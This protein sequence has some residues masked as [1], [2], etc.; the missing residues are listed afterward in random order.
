[1]VGATGNQGS[2]VAKTFL[3]LSNWHVRCLTRNPSSAASKSLAA[4]GAEIVQGD[5]EDQV[6]LQEAFEGA[7]AIF[8]NTDFRATYYAT[9]AKLEAEKKSVEPASQVAFDYETTSGKNAANVAAALPNL[10]R[11]IYSALGPMKGNSG[12]KNR[13]LHPEAKAFIVEYI[14]NKLPQLAKKTSFIYLGAYNTNR[15][16]TPALD[17]NSGK[18]TFLLPLKKDT[19]IPMID[20]AESTGPFVR[21]LIE[22]EGPGKKLLAYDSYLKVEDVVAEW[23]KASGKEAVFVH[24]DIRTMH[25]RFGFPYEFLDAL[26]Y[27]TEFGYVGGVDGIIEPAQ[28]KKKVRTKPLEEWLK[29]RNWEEVLAT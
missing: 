27:I 7:N 29:E 12:G 4:Q 5:L 15:M 26:A 16:L 21:S 10:E 2:S 22:D 13:S 19:M 1:M 18:Y 6:S 3:A 14:E 20:A 25:E 9:K 24:S 23:S 28:L 17:P 11:F 8:L